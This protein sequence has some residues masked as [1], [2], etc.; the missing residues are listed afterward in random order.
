MQECLTRRLRR[1]I[2]RERPCLHRRKY[3]RRIRVLLRARPSLLLRGRRATKAITI[4]IG[5]LPES[6]VESGGLCRQIE[7]K[8]KGWSQ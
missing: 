7:K 6:W 8:K 1:R 4:T 3:I 5:R 2:I